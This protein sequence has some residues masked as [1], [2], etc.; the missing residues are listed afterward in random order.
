MKVRSVAL[1][2]AIAFGMSSG[3]CS[4]GSGTRS[5]TGGSSSGGTGGGAG[6]GAGGGSCSN[7]TPCGGSAVGRWT[8]TSSCLKVTG[9]LDLSLGGLNCAPAPVTGSLQVTGTW[10]ANSD[11]TYSDSTTTTGTEQLSLAAACLMISGT[12]TTCAGIAGP[13]QGLGFKSLTCTDAAGGGCTCSGTIQQPGWPG[14]ISASAVA[15]GNYEASGNTLMIDGN[16]QYSYCVSGNKMTWTPQTTGVITTGTVVFQS[17]DTA[18]TGG[19]SGAGG[20]GGTGGGAAGGTGGNGGAGGAGAGGTGG[21]GGTTVTTQGPCDIYAGAN[22]PCVAAYSPV[23]RLLSTYTGALYQVRRA[24]TMITDGTG[25]NAKTGIRAGGTT[26]DIGIAAGGFADSAAQDAFCGTDSCTFSIIYDQSGQGNHLRVAPAG[27]YVDGSANL[28]DYESSAKQKSLMVGGHRVYALYTNTREGYRNNAT[29]GVPMS[30]MPQG[31]YEV[32][33]GT[34][35]GTAC[36]WDFG[37]VGKDNCNGT[38][39]N[40]IFF[41]VGFWGRGTGNGPWF[42]GDFEGGVWSGGNVGSPS[43]TNDM[44]AANPSLA[45]PYA[46]GILK[47]STGSPGQYALRMGNAQSGNLTT[48]YDGVSPK[49]WNNGGGIVLGT[50]G[51]NSNHSFGTFFEGAITMGRP[52]DGTDAAVLANVQAAGY[53]K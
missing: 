27:C 33:D 51:D 5:G 9:Q 23:R 6:G 26:Q 28:P 16:A 40:T 20:A 47:T 46:F 48:A 35:A 38:T 12:T 24:G 29:A 42:M 4:S 52:S 22:N 21:A 31:I 19:A 37:N 2:L 43:A 41:G 13:V 45:V 30:N 50:G 15:N 18:G 11:G 39:M 1:P 32:A 34:H 25:A 10:T 7:V 14:N 3:A 49:G 53:G 17:S 44:T 36:C 8:V